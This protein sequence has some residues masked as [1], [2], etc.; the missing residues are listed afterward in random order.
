[1]DTSSDL[2]EHKIFY[3]LSS[4]M[5]LFRMPY[6][7]TLFGLFVTLFAFLLF[8]SLAGFHLMIVVVV[9]IQLLILSVVGLFLTKRDPRWFEVFKGCIEFYKLNFFKMYNR[10]YEYLS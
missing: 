3:S 5:M 10:N 2:E 4:I 8:V 1:M 6:N 9:L 7:Y